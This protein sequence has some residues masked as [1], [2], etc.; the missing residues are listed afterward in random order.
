[1]VI[2]TVEVF[3]AVNQRS[4]DLLNI[5]ALVWINAVAWIFIPYA[6]HKDEFRMTT[7]VKMV[8]FIAMPCA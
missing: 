2:L 5:C 4:Q 3:D 8:K 6:F 1:M 7:A